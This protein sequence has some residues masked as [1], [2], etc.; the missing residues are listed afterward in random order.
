MRPSIPVRFRHPCLVAG[1]MPAK[2]KHASNADL[3]N[4]L[5]GCGGHG[6]R[7]ANRGYWS[8]GRGMDVVVLAYSGRNRQSR[9]YNTTKKPPSKSAACTVKIHVT[10]R[11][12]C[13]DIHN[14]VKA[15]K[16]YNGTSPIHCVGS[17]S[18]CKRF[19]VQNRRI[20]RMKVYY[21]HKWSNTWQ[22]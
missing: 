21:K 18:L 17:R 8:G 20:A 16:Q 2:T 12:S 11:A 1:N 6:A 15:N 10:H 14:L 22:D 5:K 4:G 7:G 3:M 13:L 19:A 9:G